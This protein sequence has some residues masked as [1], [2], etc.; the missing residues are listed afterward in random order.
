MSSSKLV[1]APG[2]TFPVDV[3][4]ETITILGMRGSGKTHAATILSEEILK[5]KLQ[6]AIIDPLG[7]W[8][9]LRAK[10]QV[11][12]ARLLN[13]LPI[14]I[15]GGE[16]GDLPLETTSGGFVARL[17]AEDRVSVI[18]DINLFSK[19][20]QRRF[21]TD[22][23]EE[24]YRLKA[25]EKYRTPLQVTIDEADSFAP[26]R[27]MH[28]S[29]R[30][31]GSVDALVR[32]GRSRG[33]GVVLV[34]QRPAVLSKDVLS[35][36]ECL[37]IL[38]LTAPQD[39]KAVQ[40]WTDIHGESE[41]T[42]NMLR[43]LP[44]L[45]RGMAYVWWPALGV[46]KKVMIRERE[47]FDSSFTPKV[48]QKKFTPK[49]LHPVDIEQIKGQMASTIEKVKNEDPRE[50]KRE[51]ARLK[52]DLAAKPEPEIVETGKTEI[53]K[54]TVPAIGKR[55]IIKLEKV[56]KE[57][58]KTANKMTEA[59]KAIATAADSTAIEIGRLTDSMLETQLEMQKM[60]TDLEELVDREIAK[61]RLVKI[62]HKG[63]AKPM[64]DADPLNMGAE[65]QPISMM[66]DIEAALKPGE[67]R[68]LQTLARRHPMTFTRGALATAAKYTASG[69]TF[70]GNMINLRRQGL[71]EESGG[72]FGITQKGFDV[73]GATPSETPQTAEETLEMWRGKLKPGEWRI[74]E[75]IRSQPVIWS[76][77]D[78]A[79]A[80]AY[81][82]SGGTFQGALITLRK[83]GLIVME[84]GGYRISEELK[85]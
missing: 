36:S 35:Q 59:S 78:I 8:W 55:T 30:M 9:G 47:T 85:A 20:E 14:I 5:R 64:P 26:Q 52:R 49:Q 80:T 33:I 29:E 75:A 51:V 56:A 19:N 70:Q 63:R 23:C 74:L 7:V 72:E 53:K 42:R 62:V 21:V 58:R 68:L 69:G 73:I 65:N 2:L 61:R 79:Q 45:E 34:T 40:A 66:A 1:I 39:R 28:G 46:F 24:L 13:G 84:D 17:V 83:I 82:A 44:S 77:E 3:I 12:R 11:E 50:L 22:F 41:Q 43:D 31:L 16:H 60:P 6:N 18:L 81:T 54:I 37:I 4:T 38:R 67:V 71:M 25:R 48:G 10:P 27:V 76:R 15:F 57:L 32:R